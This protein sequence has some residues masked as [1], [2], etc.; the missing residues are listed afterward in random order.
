MTD[1]NDA[2]TRG[3][4]GIPDEAKL[5]SMSY[6]ELAESFSD[7]EKGSTK[8]YVVEREMLRR[9][10]KDQMVATVIGALI[11]GVF[12]LVGGFLANLF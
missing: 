6:I 7:S 5:K 9:K 8:Y 1:E 4:H 3:F 11:G 2:F 12:T 10:S